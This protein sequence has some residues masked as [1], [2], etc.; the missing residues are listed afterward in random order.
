MFA[1]EDKEPASVAL[2]IALEFCALMLDKM[3]DCDALT[4]VPLPMA[5]PFPPI[6]VPLIG[7][8]ATAVALAMSEVRDAE[9]SETTELAAAGSEGFRYVWM[10]EGRA[11]NQLGVAPAENSEAIS[12]TTAAEFVRASWTSV[13][14]RAVWRTLRRETLGFVLVL[15]FRCTEMVGE[16]THRVW[17]PGQQQWPQ[18]RK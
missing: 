15:R 2:A 9:R 7:P 8:G 4:A 17:S 3:A 18:W 12:E 5:V 10:S 6:A 13:E 14:G 11:V 16:L 1:P